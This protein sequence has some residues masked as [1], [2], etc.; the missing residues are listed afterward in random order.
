MG[1]EFEDKLAEVLDKQMQKTD[2][3]ADSFL[4]KIKA[5]KWTAF[6]LLGVVVAVIL[7]WLVG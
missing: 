3:K 5:S 1:S 6:M 2:E 4:D 7:A